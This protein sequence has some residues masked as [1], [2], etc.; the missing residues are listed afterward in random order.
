M[1]WLLGSLLIALLVGVV[2]SQRYAWWRGAVADRYPRILMYHMVS[3][4][5]PKAK[6]NKLRVTPAN[7][8]TQIN[9]MVQQGYR[10]F[11]MSELVRRWQAG[12]LPPKSVAITFDDGYQDNLTNALPVLQRHQIPATIYV[13]VERHDNDWST[14][15]KAHH[16]SGELMQEPK[17]SDTELQMLVAS[18]LIEIGGHT[19][20]HANL[21]AIDD[22]DRHWEM[23]ESRR[24]LQQQTGQSVNSF[25]YP[26]GIYSDNDVI[27]AKQLGY[28]HAVTT[29]EGIDTEQPDFMKLKRIKISGKDSLF[30]V[31]LRL[32][33]GKRGK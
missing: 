21:N 6:F 3:A 2:L 5:R 24:I 27:M 28:Q 8:A 30:A 12:D 33:T 19:M 23:A 26:F 17:L 16:N 11:T 9:W 20:T 14:Q 15:K 18:G 7:F 1:G 31:K 22:T 25:A 10:F 32:K 4:H 29:V 13:V